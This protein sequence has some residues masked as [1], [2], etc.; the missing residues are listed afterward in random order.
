MWNWSWQL[1]DCELHKLRC[2]DR[3]VTSL[4]R[5]KKCALLFL[6]KDWLTKHTSYARSHKELSALTD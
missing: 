6:C 5:K 3:I 2:I 1:H 4:Y